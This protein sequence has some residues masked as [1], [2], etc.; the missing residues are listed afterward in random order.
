MAILG[1]VIVP[2]PPLIIPAVGRGREQEVQATIDALSVVLQ[3]QLCS[4]CSESRHVSG[5]APARR[6]MKVVSV[7]DLMGRGDDQHLR[8]P[9]GHLLCGGPVSIDGSLDFLLPPASHRGG[10]S[11]S[12]PI[13][14]TLPAQKRAP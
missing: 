6:D 14:N 10:L 13:K 12:G 3:A 9:C 8:L 7:H 1:A 2:H 4:G 5:G 11:T